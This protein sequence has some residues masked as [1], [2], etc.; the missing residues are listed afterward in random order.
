MGGE[1]EMAFFLDDVL[2]R[3]T[4]ALPRVSL[5]GVSAGTRFFRGLDVEISSIYGWSEIVLFLCL[6]PDF[7]PFVN[8]F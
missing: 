5:R 8:E 7:F 6:P 3:R 1:A 4:R 2:S